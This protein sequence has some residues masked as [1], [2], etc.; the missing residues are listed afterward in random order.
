MHVAY[1]Q[2]IDRRLPLVERACT[3]KSVFGSRREASQRA[4]RGR[5]TDGSL[6]PYRCPHCTAW[7]LG[8]RRFAF[9]PV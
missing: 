4:R 5:H 8:H 9:G 6:R 1:R 3:S 7:H 2:L